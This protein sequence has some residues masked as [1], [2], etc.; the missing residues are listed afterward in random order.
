MIEKGKV[1]SVHYTGK[2]TE[3]GEVFD[4]SQGK[5]PITFQVGSG[6]IIPGFENPLLGKNIGDK[7]VTGTIKPEDAYGSVREDLIVEVD[8]NLMP[9]EVEVG[10]T[11]EAQ[12]QNGQS[13]PVKIVEVNEEKVKIDGNHPLAGKEIQFEI[14]VVSIQD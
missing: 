3:S 14:E 7:I 9:G 12:S 5:D 13:A 1:I 6:Q 4:S 10:M 11:L 2:L 8:K